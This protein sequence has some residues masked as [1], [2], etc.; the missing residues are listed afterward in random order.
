VNEAL[1]KQERPPNETALQIKQR[2]S[3][4][5]D[6]LA[7]AAAIWQRSLAEGGE[8]TPEAAIAA[9]YHFKTTGETLGRHSYIA[10]KSQGKMHAGTVIEGY[11]AVSRN[12]D[13]SRYQWRHRPPTDDEKALHGIGPKDKAMVCEVDVLE[14][15]RKCIQMGIPYQPVIGI[16]VVRDGERLTVPANRTA[17]WVLMKQAKND[18]LRQLG[19][20]VTADE[21]FEDSEEGQEVERPE[22][23]ISVQQAEQLIA[24]AQLMAQK[25]AE[26][27]G[28]TPDEHAARLQKNVAQMRGDSDAD[29]FAE[30]DKPP[31]EPETEPSPP[32]TPE[33]RVPLTALVMELYPDKAAQAG[34]K[35]WMTKRYGVENIKSLSAA[36]VMDFIAE[37]V[38]Q[39]DGGA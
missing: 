35:I 14:A 23:G 8:M 38:K 6:I 12:L 4:D 15:R 18:A 1:I 31:A 36:Q 34:L 33:Q 26:A 37:L 13:M 29:P 24:A 2:T 32:S 39:K 19:E 30:A 22:G 10:W 28:M 25:N 3:I 7:T 5:P 16:T 17:T 11:R 9:A 27:A 21:A 20:H